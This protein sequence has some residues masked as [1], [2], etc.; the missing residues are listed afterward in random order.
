[1]P[2]RGADTQWYKNALKNPSIQIDARGA[3]AELNVVPITDLRQGASVIDNFH[4]KY[5]D[6]GMELYSKLDVAALA[7]TLIL[8]PGVEE[9]LR[10]VRIDSCYASAAAHIV[11]PCSSPASKGS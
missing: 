3:E 4:A 7:E 10:S 5:G 1:L 6:E 8:H 9:S 2:A 11:R